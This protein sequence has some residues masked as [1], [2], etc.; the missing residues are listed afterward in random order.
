MQADCELTQVQLNTVAAAMLH[1]GWWRTRGC[2]KTLACK[3]LIYSVSKPVPRMV[4]RVL[5]EALS[6]KLAT[7]NSP[8]RLHECMRMAVNLWS[9]VASLDALDEWTVVRVRPT[10][11]GGADGGDGGTLRLPDAAPAKSA[12]PATKGEKRLLVI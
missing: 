1:A 8:A 10:A 4:S 9:L 2:V 12:V 7:L 5:A 3:N 11:G 6:T